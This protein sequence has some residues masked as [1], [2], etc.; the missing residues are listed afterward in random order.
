MPGACADSPAPVYGSALPCRS[1]V[2]PCVVPSMI[3]NPVANS[4]PVTPVTVVAV[5]SGASNTVTPPEYT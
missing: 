5:A 1:R 2:K 3:A 4:L